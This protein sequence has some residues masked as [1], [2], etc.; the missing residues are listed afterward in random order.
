MRPF[1]FSWVILAFWRQLIRQNLCR[2]AALCVRF[3]ADTALRNMLDQR[4]T[5][6]RNG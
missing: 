6:N 2:V 4:A 1:F 3:G 5:A